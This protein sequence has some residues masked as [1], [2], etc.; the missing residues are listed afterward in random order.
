M[1][2]KANKAKKML[3]MVIFITSIVWLMFNVILYYKF[4]N[5]DILIFYS[6]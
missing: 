4:Q 6:I 2:L 3:K 1:S 5:S